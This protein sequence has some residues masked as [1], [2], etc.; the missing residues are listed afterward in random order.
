[1][2]FDGDSLSA[3][4]DTPWNCIVGAPTTVEIKGLR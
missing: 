1:M 2:R 3:A 4:E